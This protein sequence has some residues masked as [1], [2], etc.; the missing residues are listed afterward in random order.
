MNHHLKCFEVAKIIWNNNH[1]T[2]NLVETSTVIKERE[3]KNDYLLPLIT[4]RRKLKD[5]WQIE[6]VIKHVLMYDPTIT[7]ENILRT[8][9]RTTNI[10]FVSM[11]YCNLLT[12]EIQITNMNRNLHFRPISNQINI[13]IFWW[14]KKTLMNVCSFICIGVEKSSKLGWWT[15]S[16]TSGCSYPGSTSGSAGTD[17]TTAVKHQPPPT[18]VPRGATNSG[19][20]NDAKWVGFQSWS[21]RTRLAKVQTIKRAL[22][23][24][25]AKTM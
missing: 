19:I 16:A 4:I 10:N 14:Y 1:G 23:Y 25:V 21:E 9:Q 7:N 15:A 8:T 20:A 17:C 12:R 13:P 18:G 11:H 3:H 24:F 5:K 2:R 22:S 6:K